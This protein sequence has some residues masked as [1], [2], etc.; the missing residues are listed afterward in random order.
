VVQAATPLTLVD[1]IR[2][3]LFYILGILAILS[4]VAAAIA[5][6][7]SI[8][9]ALAPLKT[10]TETADQIIHADDLS[11]RIPYEGP[12]DE[13]GLLIS[14][15]NST[16]E[17][18]ES[19]F[20]AQQRFLADVSHELR[21]PLTVIKGNVDLIRKFGPDDES[22]DSIKDEIDRLNRMVGD[23]LLLARAESGKLPLN[24][25][26]VEMDTLLLKYSTK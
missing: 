5:S 14:A 18:L 9:R 19:L 1:S 12:S 20:T 23:L 7:I 26:P 3:L 17:R 2:R 16:L 24:L 10:A 11:R 13:I 6:W 25:A 22:L 4:M 15:F 8:G 21:T